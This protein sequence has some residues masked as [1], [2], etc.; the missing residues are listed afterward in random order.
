MEPPRYSNQ[1]FLTILKVPLL[2]NEVWQKSS[3]KQ[4]IVTFSRLKNVAKQINL[5]QKSKDKNWS[6]LKVPT[7]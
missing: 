1:K 6:F 7:E 2:D 3:R 5:K 4:T